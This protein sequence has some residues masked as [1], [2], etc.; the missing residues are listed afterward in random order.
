MFLPPT[1]H[2]E[3]IETEP[4]CISESSHHDIS[5][6]KEANKDEDTHVDHEDIENDAIHDDQCASPKDKPEAHQNE[7]KHNGLIQDEP[8]DIVPLQDINNDDVQI[9]ENGNHQNEL[10]SDHEDIGSEG[11][12]DV[13]SEHKDT[14]SEHEDIGFKYEEARL[15]SDS[16][17]DEEV[18][19]MPQ[20]SDETMAKEQI[21]RREAFIS[22]KST[23][24]EETDALIAEVSKELVPLSSNDSMD[25]ATTVYMLDTGGQPEFLDIL[26]LILRGPAFYMIFFSLALSLDELYEVKYIH[27]DESEDKSYDYKSEY[28]VAHILSRLVNTF[29]HLDFIDRS[30]HFESKAFLFGTYAGADDE[31]AQSNIDINSIDAKLRH[32][33]SHQGSILTDAQKAA[34]G[35]FGSTIFIPVDNKFGSKSEITNIQNY[36]ARFVKKVKPIKLPT[37]W[38]LFHFVLRRRCEQNK[39]E[40]V[41]KLEKVI[42]LAGRCGIESEHVKTILTYIHE[43]LGTILYF[44]NIP[45]LNQIVI[46]NPEVLFRFL[47]NLIASAF[48]HNTSIHKYGELHETAFHKI[49]EET[50]S[51]K[52]MKME[53]IVDLLKHYKVIT[54]IT[55]KESEIYS[56]T[57]DIVYLMPSLLRPNTNV[58]LHPTVYDID[59]NALVICFPCSSG[60]ENK[61]LVPVGVNTALAVELHS[62]ELELSEQPWEFVKK[63][64]YKNK[65]SFHAYGC[66]IVEITTRSSHLEVTCQL[67]DETA[68]T[69]PHIKKR[70]QEDI[71]K[72]LK[73]ITEL[74]KYPDPEFRL[75]CCYGNYWHLVRYNERSR[76]LKC[77]DSDCGS[78][79]M[80]KASPEQIEWFHEVSLL[81][82]L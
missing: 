48:E 71:K 76:L 31:A 77:D 82:K 69:T 8:Q 73:N 81:I 14:S 49:L 35:S 54:P 3:A 50:H 66:Y 41:S 10:N 52:L 9:E 68:P 4:E 36:L 2:E 63:H 29:S 30:R 62:L 65:L 37:N 64:R 25:C 61:W 24:Y 19:D 56:T 26:P 7:H 59:K 67:G 22:K 13:D 1:L 12:V 16:I 78:G 44:E 18:T 5:N 53:Y 80:V 40:E 57:T 51:N 70:I 28:S 15:N 23:S 74:Y 21:D 39:L 32:V 38:L 45:G 33:F 75:Y 47:S 27:K 6:H 34:G 55:E 43:H 72:A 79:I 42:K 58:S 11:K 46:C 60:V 17:I 20:N